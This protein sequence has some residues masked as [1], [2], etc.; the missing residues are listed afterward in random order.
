V[1][2]GW[3]EGV[4]M[5][6]VSLLVIAL[7]GAVVRVVRGPH[8]ADRV[9]ALDLVAYITVCIIGAGSMLVEEGPLLD[10]ALVLSLLAFLGTVAFARFLERV[11][12][13]KA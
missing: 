12:R 13:R 3:F 1:P 10:V 8:L 4:L 6:V 2:L 11:H 9:V 7:A 5:G